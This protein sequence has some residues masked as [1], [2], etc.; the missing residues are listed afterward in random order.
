MV[1]HSLLFDNRGSALMIFAAATII[2][3]FVQRQADENFLRV[4]KK[5][6]LCVPLWTAYIILVAAK[7]APAYALRP[8]VQFGFFFFVFVLFLTALSFWIKK[9][10]RVAFILPILAFALFTWIFSG[11]R[12]LCPSTFDHVPEKICVEVSRH[13]V[14]QIIA[15][16]RAGLTKVV[17]TVPKGDDNDNWPHPLYM[18]KNISRTLHAHGIISRRLDVTILP[19]AKLNE[20]FS[21]KN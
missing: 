12:T 7:S 21:L 3:V 6:L 19:D 5:F 14:N 4:L 18:G 15:A 1:I 16:D 17:V 9:F 8:D 20:R 13:I 2:F 10:P 11:K